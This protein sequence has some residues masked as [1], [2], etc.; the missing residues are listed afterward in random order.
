M[1]V[2][3]E[4]PDRHVFIFL[5]SSFYHSLPPIFTTPGADITRDEVR[6]RLVAE[7]NATLET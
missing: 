7:Q 4:Q 3:N 2:K 5:P 6:F 1:V